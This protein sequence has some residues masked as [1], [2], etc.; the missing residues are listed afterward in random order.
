MLDYFRDDVFG[1]TIVLLLVSYTSLEQH[2]EIFIN[3][4]SFPNIFYL[5]TQLNFGSFDS[6][7]FF[8]LV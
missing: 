7:Y 1:L 2:L 3:L 8:T 5:L 6:V 4:F